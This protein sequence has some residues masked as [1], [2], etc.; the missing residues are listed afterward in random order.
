MIQ[1]E[2]FPVAWFLQI[3]WFYLYNSERQRSLKDVLPVCKLLDMVDSTAGKRCT[4]EV[5]G[6]IAAREV[7][8]YELLPMQ[9]IKRA[10]IANFSSAFGVPEDQLLI[11]EKLAASP[12]PSYTAKRR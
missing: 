5:I 3:G 8:D 7:F 10:D 4:V 2:L 11:W 6:D 1:L 9:L 12:L